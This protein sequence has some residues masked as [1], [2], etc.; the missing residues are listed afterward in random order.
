MLGSPTRCEPPRELAGGIDWLF[1]K[2]AE[3]HARFAV[4][5][6]LSLLRR[7]VQQRA[8]FI[9]RS[10]PEPGEDP[11]IVTIIREVLGDRLS[12]DPSA[13]EWRRLTQRIRELIAV[14]NKRKNLVG[15]GFED[16]LAA[17][18]RKFDLS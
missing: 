6:Y 15:E 2:T 13:D 16:V 7:A 10:F 1:Q 9:D 17:V 14:E 8:P 5:R 4:H 12:S 11:A 3:D 18:V